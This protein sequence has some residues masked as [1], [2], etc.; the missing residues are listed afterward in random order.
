[1]LIKTQLEKVKIKDAFA[2]AATTYDAVAD[3]QREVGL[4]LLGQVLRKDLTGIVLDV[5]CGTGFL[6]HKVLIHTECVTV[7]G[8]DI[9]LPMLQATRQKTASQHLSLLCA[10]AEF[11]PLASE[12]VHQIVSNLALQWCENLTAVFSDFNR[13]LKPQG[14]LSF[15]T[16]GEKTLQELKAAW[17][18]VDDC[19]H[20]NHFYQA[21]EIRFF[22]QQAGFQAIEIKT[23]TYL[24][25]YESVMALMHELKAL[26]AHHVIRGARKTMTGKTKMQTMICDYET[27]RKK[28][29]IPA[30]FEIITVTARG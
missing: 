9:A 19:C 23:K 27:R 24:S 13:V 21:D 3:L 18:T 7:I 10:D 8:L 6:T 14:Q 12:S 29:L 25:Q 22:L 11:L 17:A 28:G 2:H 15:S 26:G 20:V 1:M 16:F 30:T 5:G 4:S